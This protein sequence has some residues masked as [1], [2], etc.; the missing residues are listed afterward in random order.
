MFATTNMHSF[1]L[2]T[3]SSHDYA[4]TS[5]LHHQ[6]YANLLHGRD[7]EKR[8]PPPATSGSHAR[9]VAVVMGR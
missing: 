4:L 3:I 8:D 5:T 2:P 1:V 7:D 6:R 9:D